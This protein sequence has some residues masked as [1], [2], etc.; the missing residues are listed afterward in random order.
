MKAAVKAKRLQQ[1]GMG[2]F[3]ALVKALREHTADAADGRAARKREAAAK[4]I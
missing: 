1:H 2:Q 3:N 4:K